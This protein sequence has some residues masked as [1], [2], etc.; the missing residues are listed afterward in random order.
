MSQGSAGSATRKPRSLT[1]SQIAKDPAKFAVWSAYHHLAEGSYHVDA[2]EHIRRNVDTIFDVFGRLPEVWVTPASDEY[3]ELSRNTSPNFLSFLRRARK[4]TP[5]L[6]SSRVAHSRSLNILRDLQA[7]FLSYTRLR[8]MHRTSSKWSEADYAAQ[9]YNVLRVP[10]GQRSEHKCQALLSL[11]QPLGQYKTS[12]RAAQNLNARTIRPDG[13]LFIPGRHIEQLSKSA[14]SPFGILSRNP[15]AN[16]SSSHGGESSFR[17]QSTLCAKLPDND[18][19]EI[20]ST[21]WEDKKPSHRELAVAYRQNRMS[22][23]TALRQLHALNIAAPIFGLVWAE[24]SVR[25]HVDWCAEEEEQVRIISAP[26]PGPPSTKPTTRRTSSSFYEWDLENPSHMIQV[27]LLLRNLDR[28]TVKEFKAIVEE[29][30]QTLASD[31]KKGRR[32]VVP[33]RRRSKGG[34]VG[35]AVTNESIST[36]PAKPKVKRSGK[37]VTRAKAKA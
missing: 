29:G 33:W 36:S 28:W 3:K 18:K 32:T 21:F 15:R 25:A 20:A 16:N 22:T 1:A 6:F 23:A 30:I 27:Y 37:R 13:L 5:N 34:E 10:A 11:P 12:A 19:F 8:H 4:E 2:P 35:A 14:N 17:W 31:V 24:G 7:V 9:V 26:Y